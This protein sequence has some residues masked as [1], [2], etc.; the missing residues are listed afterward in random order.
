MMA[1]TKFFDL[2]EPK[3]QKNEILV[4]KDKYFNSK[5]IAIVTGA[6]SGIGRATA[7]ALAVN[8]LTV[9]G[10]DVNESGGKET[11]KMA[12]ALG[13]EVIFMKTDLTT[14]DEIEQCIRGFNLWED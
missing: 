6:A 8:G 11:V 13:G 10:N 12:K 14:D 1:K 4:V 5:N 2:D 7:V 3:I 9:V